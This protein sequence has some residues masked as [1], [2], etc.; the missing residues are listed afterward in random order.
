MDYEHLLLEKKDGIATITLNNPERLNAVSW[1]MRRSLIL[2]VAE[3]AKDD[4]IKVAIVTGAGRGFCAGADL[5]RGEGTSSPDEVSRQTLIHSPVMYTIGEPFVKLTKPVIAAINGVCAGMG[6]SLILSCD[7]R[8][9]SEAA[10]FTSVWILRGMVPDNAFTYLLSN[11]IGRA[12]AME[13]MLTGEQVKAAEAERLGIVSRVVPPDDLMKV[14]RELA[15][16]LAQQPPITLELTKKIVNHGM[17]EIMARYVDLESRAQ[18]I[19]TQTE[20][21]KEAVRAFLEKL[22]P[23]PFKGK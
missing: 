4:E 3:V 18:Q 23:A 21:H 19:S 16:K 7:I 6:F 8:I 11:A 17:A 22:P 10:R 1:G 5:T 9:A 12:K 2:A 13:L 15:T 14:A 20:D